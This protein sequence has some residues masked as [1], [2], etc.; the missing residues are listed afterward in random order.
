MTT[1]E[2]ALAYL[3]AEI[4]VIPIARDGSKGPAV[5][6]LPLVW[7]EREQKKKRKWEPYQGVRA[8]EKTAKQWWDTA[9]PTG[10]AMI[11]GAIS[12]NREVLDFDAEAEVLFP[13]WWNLVESETAG[14]AA[15][16]CVHQTP[17]QP[18][19]Y[20][21]VFRCLEV[22]TP[23][24]Q[25]LAGLSPEEAEAEK[26]LAK[27]EGRK[28]E[29][30][31][32]ET[33]GEGGYILVPGCPAECHPSHG[34]YQHVSGP[35][36]CDLGTVTADERECLLRCAR[37]F[38]RSAVE[39]S[40]PKSTPQTG[41][42]R[43]GDDFEQHGMSWAELLEPAGWKLHSRSG[44]VCYWTRPDKGHGVSATTG[45]CK[46][47][48]DGAELMRV[49][50]S[51]AAPFEPDKS[52]GKFRV[53]CLLQAGG[54]WKG[55]ASLLRQ[56]GYGGNNGTGKGT[57]DTRTTEPDF[58]LP[59]SVPWP[60]P[61]EPATWYGLAGEIV[62]AIEPQTEAD[63]IAI[64]VQ[65]L[66]M[67]GNAIGRRPFWKVENDRHFG[68]LFG[69]L[70][71]ETAKGRKGTSMGR[72]RQA[73][74]KLSG[75]WLQSRIVSGLSSGEG[76]LWAVRDPIYKLHHVKQK[77]RITET[78]NIL[79]DEGVHDKRLLVVESEFSLVLRAMAREGNTLSARLRDLWDTGNSR[80][81][82]KNSPVTTTNAHVSLLAH[83]TRAELLKALAEVEMANGFANRFLWVAVKRSK[84]LPLGGGEIDLGPLAHKLAL[85]VEQA[86]LA[87]EI[88]FDSPAS[89]LFYPLYADLT[90][91]TPGVRGVVTSRAEAQ[92]RRLAM[93]Y[94]LL[95]FSSTVGIPHL[96]AAYALWNYCARSVSWVFGEST[97]NKLADDLLEALKAAGGQGMSG[98]DLHAATGRNESAANI[99]RAMAMLVESRLAYSRP[100]HTGG[101]PAKRWWFG[102]EQNEQTNKAHE[103]NG[104]ATQL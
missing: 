52:Y 83:I 73:F 54:D 92:V 36:L 35:S 26:A 14:L 37:A 42:L 69:C 27:A 50:S 51:N 101:R 99:A 86:Q 4:S 65:I 46:R 17:R 80:C 20:H 24:N 33:R 18:C 57:S 7:D 62:R 6:L 81:L 55:G 103:M 19:A 40:R 63:P 60:S 34:L 45:Y 41:D 68:N 39:D 77:G 22:L 44:E 90:V 74:E 104:H 47:T 23:G 43:P 59:D 97:G 29:L 95:D 72:A 82:T 1:L 61:P 56:L 93:L 38:D 13:A 100:V 70:V 28:A 64:L 8:S 91:G 10:I 53:F 48:W 78:Q 89:H 75:S 79:D 66:V 67:F 88:P 96:E 94:A 31:L 85:A 3:H 16:C 25:K 58:D 84:F 12:G 21:V 71:G 98:R 9:E 2:Q 49:F 32:I 102:Y 87:D 5:S 15:R 11:G 30:T 76:L